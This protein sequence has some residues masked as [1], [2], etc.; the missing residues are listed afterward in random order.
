MLLSLRKAGNVFYNRN[1]IQIELQNILSEFSGVLVVALAVFKIPELS[2][3]GHQL[4]HSSFLAVH[5]SSTAWERMILH[6]IFGIKW[7]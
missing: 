1:A 7:S 3:S 5:R 2:V 6:R 4:E